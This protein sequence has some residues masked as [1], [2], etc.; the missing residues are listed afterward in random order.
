MLY[1]KSDNGNI[2]TSR[3]NFIFSNVKNTSNIDKI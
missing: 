3:I 2:A 1:T